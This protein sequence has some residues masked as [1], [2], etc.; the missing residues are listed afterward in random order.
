[1]PIAPL[2]ASA[3]KYF[4]G[5]L[6][7]GAVVQLSAAFTQVQLAFNWYFDHYLDIA[8]WLA[9]AMRVV[10]LVDVLER[11]DGETGVSAADPGDALQD[12][13]AAP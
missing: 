12:S 4:A 1:M 3:P 6:T 2:L 11:R 10:T 5:E 8:D 13:E 7:L 9:N